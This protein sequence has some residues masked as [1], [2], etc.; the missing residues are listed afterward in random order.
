MNVPASHLDIQGILPQTAAPA[1]PADCLAGI[2]AEHV[3]VLY[4]VLVCLDPSEKLVQPY[5]RILFPVGSPSLPDQPALLSGKVMPRFKYRN[6]VPFGISYQLIPEPSHL[7]PS[8]AGDRP[9]VYA[10]ALV[11]YDKF[12]ADTD[13]LSQS[14]AYGTGPERAVETEHIFIR[15]PECNPIRLEPVHELFHARPF[16]SA[17]GWCTGILHVYVHRAVSSVKGCLHR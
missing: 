14:A 15:L 4:L 6:P 9:I 11:R 10:L 12:L 13:Y 7:L 16:R 5:Q 3:F 8:P 1:F 2:A 17:A